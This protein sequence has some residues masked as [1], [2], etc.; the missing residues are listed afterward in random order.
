MSKDS[1]GEGGL[2]SGGRDTNSRS[3]SSSG[4]SGS[5]SSSSS[6]NSKSES[7][8]SG[9]S[10]GNGGFSHGNATG[11]DGEPAQVSSGYGRDYSG[12]DGITS[13]MAR[14]QADA[15]WADYL[16]QYENERWSLGKAW[17][18]LTGG[19]W[20][21]IGNVAGILNEGLNKRST[22]EVN[23]IGGGL[24]SGNWNFDGDKITKDSVGQFGSALS[25]GLGILGG[26]ASLVTG[27]PLG[28]V[29]GMRGVDKLRDL[30]NLNSNMEGILGSN[31]GMN[32]YN[33]DWTGNQYAS[34]SQ[35]SK[36]RTSGLM[37]VLGLK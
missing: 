11:W 8:S 28:L 2:S 23:Q 26:L 33:A 31:A 22:D 29:T 16:D 19:K 37:T 24:M 21:H 3:S 14:R 5:S 32:D 36:D 20:S 9:I 6:R 27:N 13:D 35:K 30:S 17:D 7:G 1:E 18:A 15:V 25:G 10:L 4:S 34:D 12:G